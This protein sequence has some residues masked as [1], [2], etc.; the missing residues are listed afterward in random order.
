MKKLMFGKI[1]TAAFY[2]TETRLCVENLKLRNVSFC[3]CVM[4]QMFR[5]G[6]T[7]TLTLS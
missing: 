3:Q 4:A 2:M 5:E 1:N 7:V 6:Q